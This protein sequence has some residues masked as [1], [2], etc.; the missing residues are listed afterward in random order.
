MAGRSLTIHLLRSSVCVG[1]QAMEVDEKP[2]EDYTD[3]GG[4]G[5]LDG[6]CTSLSAREGAS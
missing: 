3:V 1:A 5:T 2:T 4:L 6:I